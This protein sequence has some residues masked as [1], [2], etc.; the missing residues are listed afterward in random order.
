MAKLGMFYFDL[1][2]YNRVDIKSLYGWIW[3]EAIGAGAA[4]GVE[5]G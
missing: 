2:K 4:P 1:W 5:P 3:L